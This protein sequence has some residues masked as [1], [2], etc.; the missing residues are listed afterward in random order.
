LQVLPKGIEKGIHCGAAIFAQ[1]RSCFFVELGVYFLI[2][3][4]SQQRQLENNE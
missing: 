2:T 3:R 1:D 4:W